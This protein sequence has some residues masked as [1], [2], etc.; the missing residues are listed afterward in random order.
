MG[1]FSEGG[2]QARRFLE[3]CS[4]EGGLWA[5]RDQDPAWCFGMLQICAIIGVLDA[6]FAEVV[7]D[8][9]IARTS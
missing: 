6:L 8:K 2:V 9:G 4:G 1:S 7:G 5:R 3:G